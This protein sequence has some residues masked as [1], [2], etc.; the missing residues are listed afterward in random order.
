MRLCVL[1][2]CLVQQLLLF[3]QI[4]SQ[5]VGIDV[6][7]N[8]TTAPG[9][10]FITPSSVNGNTDYPSQLLLLDANGDP[11]YFYT[12]SN[13]SQAPY[14]NDWRIVNFGMA[15]NDSLYFIKTNA[16][17]NTRWVML[18]DSN[19]Q[20]VDST[21]CN[22]YYY[23]IHEF[24]ATS[25]GHE[26]V[27][28]E[29]YRPMDLSPYTTANGT[30][31]DVNGEIFGQVIQELD[32]NGSVIHEWNTIDNFS[33]AETDFTWF[34]NPSVLDHAHLNSVEIDADGNWIISARHLNSVFKVNK[35][36]G[37][38]MWQLGGVN[39][40]F[41][42]QNDTSWFTAQHDARRLDNG[43]ISLFDNAQLSYYPIARGLE[44]IL[45]TNSW[46][47]TLVH[48][49][50][51]PQLKF[52]RFMGNYQTLDNNHH[53]I[54]WGGVYPLT[55]TRK[56]E[57]FDTNDDLVLSLQFTPGYL[58]YRA[59]KHVLPFELPRPEIDCDQ[60]T[61]TLT[62]EA[63]YSTYIWSTGDTSNVITLTDTGHYAVWVDYGMGYLKSNEFYVE[64]LSNIC[65]T[66]GLEEEE[67]QF[68]IYPNPSNDFWT[69]SSGINNQEYQLFSLDGKII[70]SGTIFHGNNVIKGDNI[71]PGIYV[72]RIANKS[73][74]LIK[75]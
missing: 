34:N 17:Q 52:S 8:N 20:I 11:Y 67:H 74:R 9:S 26:V 7:L 23:D 69:V 63:G 6:Q 62:A 44:Y 36:N 40:Q 59:Y 25:D 39:N 70:S 48:S 1:I 51:N 43:N 71:V 72:L 65:Q 16:A 58:S 64:D 13:Q 75:Q 61:M 24:L 14:N 54:D 56:V 45:D 32:V 10:I 29:E 3:A 4:E 41:T 66:L 60:S 30:Q 73:Y 57:E 21:A 31:G 47:A 46:T 19:M 55:Q 42:L 22:A 5:I 15:E 53:L 37:Q 35:V 12:L 2:V 27:M 68:S 49:L 18:V 38:L 50:D 28:C 33:V